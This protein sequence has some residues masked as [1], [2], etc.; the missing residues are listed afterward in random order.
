M[1]TFDFIEKS[2]QGSGFVFKNNDG[3]FFYNGTTFKPAGVNA[4]FTATTG[5]G[6]N[7]MNISA[8]LSGEVGVGQ[9]ITGGSLTG[10]FII[11][12]GT[13]NGISGTVNLSIPQTWANP[14]TVTATTSYPAETV[15]GIVYLDGTYYVMDPN[16]FIYGSNINDPTAWDPVNV[17]SAQSEPDTAVALARQTNFVVAFGAYSTEFFYNAANPTGSPLLP[18]ANSFLQIGCASAESVT[19]VGNDLVFMSVGRQKGRSIQYLKGTVPQKI[20]TPYVDRILDNDRLINVSAFYVELKGHGFYVLNLPASNITLV[21]DFATQLWGTWTQLVARLPTIPIT[22]MSWVDN[23]VTFTA[24]GHNKQDGDLVLITNAIPPAY[25]GQK[26]VN[27]IDSNTLSYTAMANPGTF[28]GTAEL[29]TY[30][31]QAFSMSSYTNTGQLN[32]VQDSTTG[33]VY[34][35]STEDFL[36]NGLPIKYRIRTPLVDGG[37]NAMKFFSRVEIIGDKEDATLYTRYTNNDYNTYS[38]YRPINLRLDKSQM[39]R[40]SRGRRRGFEMINYDNKPIRLREL[41]LFVEKG[42]A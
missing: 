36:D 5:S 25:N 39:Y 19:R 32:L 9:R 40:L 14:T 24:T 12:L 37:L 35:L 8:V 38:K 41:E 34:A 10:A 33:A 2:S 31:E 13:F 20:S 18:Y 22:A 21:Y 7:V 3:L 1:A 17:I 23:T 15:R 42:F 26:V 11:S 4:T 29:T 16:G 6:T 28:S 27:V 30:E